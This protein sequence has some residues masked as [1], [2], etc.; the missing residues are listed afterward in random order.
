MKKI[1]LI[2]LGII[3][4]TNSNVFAYAQWQPMGPLPTPIPNQNYQPNPVNRMSPSQ[5]YAV[6]QT[7]IN[8][9]RA[10]QQNHL[11]CSTR[12]NCLQL[13][14]NSL[15]DF[16]YRNPYHPARPL[17]QNVYNI[18][19]RDAYHQKFTTQW[20]IFQ[21]LS[22]QRQAEYQQGLRFV[23]IQPQSVQTYVG[24]VWVTAPAQ[25]NQDDVFTALLQ[26]EEHYNRNCDVYDT[27]L[28]G[29]IQIIRNLYNRLAVSDPVRPSLSKLA[30]MIKNVAN[31]QIFNTI[32][33]LRLYNP[34]N[35]LDWDDVLQKHKAK[36]VAN[37][38]HDEWK[39]I[40]KSS[41]ANTWHSARITNGSPVDSNDPLRARIQAQ[42]KTAKDWL[43]EN[44][45]TLKM[46]SDGQKKILKSWWQEN[47]NIWKELW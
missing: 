28:T 7:F 2:S 44:K 13:D 45:E 42:K 8:A 6:N 47:K 27:C 46:G 17:I 22:P 19:R 5:R 31:R 23:P 11:L 43:Q 18:I 38:G 33:Y 29:N 1:I 9:E 35:R 15:S 25:F 3:I 24:G 14:L 30:Q 21:Q 12:A 40:E 4:L 41:R 32:V 36:N 26:E 16:I 20:V 10:F 37:Y 39:K 34:L